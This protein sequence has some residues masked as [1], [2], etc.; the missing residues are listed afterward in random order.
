MS[1]A[2]QAPESDVRLSTLEKH[3]EIEAE[4]ASKTGESL[5]SGSIVAARQ[6]SP[7][8]PGGEGG[9]RRGGGIASSQDLDLKQR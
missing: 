2:K 6:S 5:R 7:S 1:Q 8:S 4:N 3:T 9:L